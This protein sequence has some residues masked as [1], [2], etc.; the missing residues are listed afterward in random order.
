MPGTT[1]T[2][3]NFAGES[4]NGGATQSLIDALTVSCNTAFAQLGMDL[5][6][7]KVRAM[8]EA[9]GMDGESTEIPLR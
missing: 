4:C 5:G 8:A 6:E 3:Q 9:F 2:L 7:D 1:A